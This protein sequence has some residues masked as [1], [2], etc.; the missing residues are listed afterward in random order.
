MEKKKNIIRITIMLMIVLCC[1]TTC[2]RPEIKPE[3]FENPAV[4][5]TITNH[6]LADKLVGS[7]VRYWE[8][9]RDTLRFSDDGLFVYTLGDFLENGNVYTDQY[10]YD[11]TNHFL[12][13]FK[14]SS[15]YIH[16]V[17]YI[18]FYEGDTLFKL[19]NFTFLPVDVEVVYD[20]LFKKID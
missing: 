11:C 18:Q 2:E 17:H 20:V 14:D 16:Q 4:S 10:Y 13:N 5:N 1:T 7:W 19:G 8:G 9:R 15:D 6:S 3:A 12:I